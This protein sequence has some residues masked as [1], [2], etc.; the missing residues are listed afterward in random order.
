[1]KKGKLIALIGSALIICFIIADYCELFVVLNVDGAR[2]I[3]FRFKFQ[4]K[5][6]KKPL[7]NISIKGFYKG[8]NILH[9]Y[10]KET[11]PDNIIKGSIWFG[12]GCKRTFFFEK[13]SF[14]KSVKDRTIEFEFSHPSYQTE[15]M[16]FTVEQLKKIQTIKLTPSAVTK[17]R[18]K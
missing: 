8:R 15:T 3:S 10:H 16:T 11:G 2:S 1:M 18:Q 7:T 14:Y 5:K 12:W 4:D 13:P 9:A 17:Q 6:T